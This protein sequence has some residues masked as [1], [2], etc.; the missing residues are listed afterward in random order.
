MGALCP[1][2]CLAHVPARLLKGRMG[3]PSLSV[4]LTLILSQQRRG[5]SMWPQGLEAGARSWGLCGSPKKRSSLPLVMVTG[6]LPQTGL[7][8]ECGAGHGCH[9][10]HQ[11]PGR[12]P[13]FPKGNPDWHYHGKPSGGFP[14][15]WAVWGFHSADLRPSEAQGVA[16][17]SE[18]PPVSVWL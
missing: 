16:G 10:E 11:G 1:V 8:E 18:A 9:Q 7:H 5:C 15:S 6:H 13:I 4:P 12:L 3:R 17:V 14:P 2:Q